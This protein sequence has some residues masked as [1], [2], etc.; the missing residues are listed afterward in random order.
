MKKVLLVSAAA[1][2]SAVSAPASAN[3][4]GGQITGVEPV[5][6]EV[7][8]LF[9]SLAFDTLTTGASINDNMTIRCNDADGATVRLRSAQGGLQSDDGTFTG[10]TDLEDRTIDYIATLA[11]NNGPTIILD[12]TTFLEF[13]DVSSED[14]LPWSPGLASGLASTLEI[15]LSESATFAGGYSDTIFVDVQARQ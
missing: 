15:S 6:C 3:V 10:L 2:V 5:V 7:E 4:G 1:L 13:D 8:D 14:D 12:T 11:I 9:A